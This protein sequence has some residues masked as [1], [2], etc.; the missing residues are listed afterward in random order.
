M[1]ESAV[2]GVGYCGGGR[3]QRLAAEAG[4]VKEAARRRRDGDG[5]GLVIHTHKEGAAAS[6]NCTERKSKTK[7]RQSM[8]TGEGRR[9]FRVTFLNT[10]VL[11]HEVAHTLRT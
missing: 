7:I 6:A 8:A 3:Q 11:P 10:V 4:K 5:S 2:E 1:V 9:G